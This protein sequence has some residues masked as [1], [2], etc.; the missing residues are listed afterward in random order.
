MRSHTIVK[1]LSDFRQ[2][3]T[4]GTWGA[5]IRMP[6]SFVSMLGV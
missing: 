4:G 6:V 2:K 5:V 3:V 1:G